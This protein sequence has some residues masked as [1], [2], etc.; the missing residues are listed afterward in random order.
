M[1]V[2]SSWDVGAP[3][4]RLNLSWGEA[5]SFWVWSPEL[6]KKTLR[7]NQKLNDTTLWIPS[8]IVEANFVNET[9]VYSSWML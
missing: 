1:A 8:K 2:E 3:G 7:K 6:P 4:L 9:G 5:I